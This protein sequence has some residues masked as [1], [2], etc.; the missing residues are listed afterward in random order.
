MALNH[1]YSRQ[2]TYKAPSARTV[3]S[4]VRAGNLGL[5]RRARR[6][7]TAI[8]GENAMLGLMQDWPLLC[9]RIIDHAATY[10]PDRRVISRSIE[11]P[12]HTTTYANI[13]KRALKVAQRL[14]R[15]GIKL[16]DRVATFAWNTLAA[17]RSLV[18]HHGDR[19]GLSHGQSAAVSRA[20]RLDRQPRRRPRA[21]H[22][23]DVPAAPGKARGPAQDDRAICRAHRRR[24]HA[25]DAAEERGALRGMD[26]RGRWRLRVEAFRREHRRR[27]V[28]HVRHH[29]RSEGRALLAP[30]QR[31]AL[32]DGGAARRHG[33]VAH[34][35]SSCRSCR[36]FTPIAGGSR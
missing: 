6:P 27:H 13:H 36:C 29:R 15:D 7:T 34:A 30:L 14:D 16:G 31:V 11:G 26:R 17:P 1:D 20:D 33:R 12:I 25:G 24:A 18:R 8:S 23:P 5:R 3:A 32:D 4:T 19:R 10:H 35:M 2:I 21:D 9:H 28:L 22:R